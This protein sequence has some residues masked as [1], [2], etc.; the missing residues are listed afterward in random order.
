[1][2]LFSFATTYTAIMTGSV[3]LL[4]IVLLCQDKFIQKVGYRVLFFLSCLTLLRLL[5]PLEFPFTI[6][7]YFPFKVSYVVSRFRVPLAETEFF[8]LSLWNILEII[9]GI[10]SAVSLF[11]NIFQHRK[12]QRYVFRY[13]RDMT[14]HSEYAT[15]LEQICLS[16]KRPNCFRIYELPGL[17]IPA[18][19]MNRLT[20]YILLPD[21]FCLSQRDM[22]FIFRHEAAHYFHGDFL[23][24]GIIRLIS[25]IYWWNPVCISLKRRTDMLLEMRIDH[26]AAGENTS[27][28]QEYIQCLLNLLKN[29]S[30]QSNNTP[31]FSGPT[32]LISFFSGET[33]D[34]EKRTNLLLYAPSRKRYRLAKTLTLFVAL[35]I[36]IL[37][38]LYIVEAYYLRP[39]IRENSYIVF[40]SENT[41][42]I[43]TDVN[44]YDI[45]YQGEYY[46]STDSLDYF[47][48][49]I[50]IYT[51]EEELP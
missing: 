40:T 15:L 5:V 42:I 23:F 12:M 24:K 35:G 10:G 11:R 44:Q 36:Y 6:T 30:A 39:E 45:Y 50:E 32:T 49:N 25:I 38:Y 4:L 9:W 7:R 22:H 46:T 21:S 16:E 13:G 48:E 17:Q 37:S 29:V 34:L 26:Y 2:P 18:I 33:R 28:S 8:T 19:W 14:E 20:P 41:Y 3:L 1:M 27:V 47:D 51:L 31:N 43:Q